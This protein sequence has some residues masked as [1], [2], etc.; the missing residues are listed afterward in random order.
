MV[1]NPGVE[2]SL[3]G[4]SVLPMAVYNMHLRFPEAQFLLFNADVGD[5]RRRIFGGHVHGGEVE[6]MAALIRTNVMGE[7]SG[8]HSFL[9]IFL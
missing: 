4:C 6:F 8:E 9:A 3:P 7:L 5:K 1:I 2:A